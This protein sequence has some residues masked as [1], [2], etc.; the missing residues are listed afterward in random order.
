MTSF[1]GRRRELSQAKD[2][3]SGS[4]LVT[5]TGAGGIGKT[6]LALRVASQVQRAF[7][8]GVWLVEEAAVTA[9]TPVDQSVMDALGLREQSSR[10]PLDILRDR[11]ADRHMLLVLDN[12]EQ[13]IDP[14]ALLVR[15]LLEAAPRLRVLATSRQTLGVPGERVL[16]VPPL[17]L[18]DLE[19]VRAPQVVST[20]EAVSLF[21]QRA[22]TV[23]PGF[24]LTADN[25]RQIAEICHRLEGIPLA[26]ELAA[27]RLRTLSMEEIL[28]RLDDRFGLLTSTCRVTVPR[29]RTLRAAIDWSFG[30]CSS[31][32]RLL[33]SRLSIFRDGFDLT[34]AEEL[35]SGKGISRR[36]VLDL[37]A[38]LVDK[39]VLTCEERGPRM[40][41]RMAETIREYGYE[42][43][44]AA[45][46]ESNL[47]ERHRDWYLDLAEQADSEWFGPN[48]TRWLERLQDECPN[49]R[50][51]LEYS[52][53]E[54][55][56]ARAGLKMAGDLW[57]F[58]LAR[59]AF[60]EARR[61]LSRGVS[62]DTADS[63]PRAKA[64]WFLG[65]ITSEQGDPIRALG[66]LAEAQSLAERLDDQKA[67]AWTMQ[68]AALAT[69]H[70]GDIAGGVELADQ[71][72][73]RQRALNDRAGILVSMH[74]LAIATSLHGDPR[75]AAIG[76]EKLALCEEMG[77][78]WAKSYALRDLG[79]EARRQGDMTR[80]KRLLKESLRLKRTLGD[81][82]GSSSCFELLAWI[83]ADEDDHERAARL[84]GSA[85]LL[86]RSL[87]T[88]NAPL[89][90]THH[91]Y[92]AQTRQALGEARFDTAFALGERHPVDDAYAYALDEEAPPEGFAT[93]VRAGG[94]FSPTRRE[95]EV[96]ALVAQGLSN[97]EIAAKLVISL[98][99]AEGHVE[100]ILTKLGFT[101]RA[102]IAVWATQHLTDPTAG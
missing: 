46:D 84:L 86:C 53:S 87:E 42:Q 26:I 66:L 58:W 48:R 43:L 90:A 13:V 85:Q 51:A 99:T 18:P 47:S 57:G 95:R 75:S 21:T 32:E 28:E 69:M 70:Q 22:D 98:R 78:T 72:L 82:L 76:E 67:L 29:Q 77:S 54:P 92:M 101:S 89:L 34:A 63:P 25:T 6:R 73:Q 39:S 81:P 10:P 33:W 3:L 5:L 56:Q 4:R 97:K 12:C 55:G 45:G 36:D 91:Q 41:Y 71:A 74:L 30:M 8:D 19:R 1:V 40:R 64:L 102:Q 27:A 11:L 38:A 49:I 96:A 23:R 20:C 83:A 17:D 93:G 24:M 80:A 44:A 2:A 37:V 79:L 14:C 35:C 61:W 60:T 100:K 62:L 52:L 31:Q 7:Q 59:G 94:V 16:H 50:A 68:F 65:W 9:G 15:A 88:S